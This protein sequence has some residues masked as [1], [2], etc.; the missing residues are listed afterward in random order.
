M[1]W[2]IEQMNNNELEFLGGWIMQIK[3]K[4]SQYT[5]EINERER[6]VIEITLNS[7]HQGQITEKIEFIKD[8][9]QDF[10]DLK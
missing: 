4:Y 9:H 5:I 1:D 7:L 8:L 10:V 3:K 6:N 2:L